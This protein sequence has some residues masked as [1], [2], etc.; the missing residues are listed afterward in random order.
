[1]QMNLSEETLTQYGCQRDASL[2]RE[3]DL[4]ESVR[5]H[6]EH[7]VADS[8]VP[9]ISVAVAR[10][11]SGPFLLG[12]M[13]GKLET[14]DVNRVRPCKLWLELKL[15]GNALNGSLITFSQKKIPP[16]R[17]LTGWI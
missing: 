6:M 14:Q 3:A 5:K 8:K 4:F 13:P 11:G 2:P 7:L 16:G 9:S 1:M 17:S 10:D 15:R 12:W